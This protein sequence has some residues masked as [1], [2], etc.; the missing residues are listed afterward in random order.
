MADDA[1]YDW[2]NVNLAVEN[3]ATDIH[4]VAFNSVDVNMGTSFCSTGGTI[5]A[6]TFLF[7][8]FQG[9]LEEEKF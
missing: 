3:S 9:F 7:D 8:T 5:P 2:F 6:N 4:S 1:N